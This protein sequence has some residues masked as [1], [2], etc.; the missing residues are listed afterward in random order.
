MVENVVPYYEPLI[1]GKKLGR[2]LVWSN[3]KIGNYDPPAKKGFIDKYG[4]KGVKELQ[5]FLGIHYE[6][7]LYYDGNH[8][9]CQVLRNCV[10]PKLGQHVMKRAREIYETKDEEQLAIFT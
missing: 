10:H 2:H 6:G 7:Q 3:F 8:E 5:N 9:P 1:P 4:E